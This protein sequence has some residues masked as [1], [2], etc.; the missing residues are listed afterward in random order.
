MSNIVAIVGRPNVGKSTLFNRLIEQKKA[1]MDNVSGVTRDRHYGYGQW[2]GKFF[3][4][5]DTGGYVHGSEDMFEGAIRE[6]VEMAME[7]ADVLLFVV[8][9][10]VGL[11]DLDKD[12]AKVLRK[13]KKPVI[14]VANKADTHDKA[15]VAAEFY[16]LGLGDP[17]AIAAESGSGTGD[18]LD[19]MV[20]HFKEEGVE[21]PEAGVPRV[22]ILGRP[23]VGK[24]SFLNAL[25]GRERS[26][27]TD[28]AGT[29][30][31]A[32]QNRYTLYGKDF[33]ITDTAGIRRKAKIDD[34]IEYYSVLR[35]IKA[36]EECDLA[37]ILVDA[38]TIDFNTG[39]EAQDMNIISMADKAKK[40]IVLMVNKWDL[41]AK[42]TNTAIKLEN[43]IKERLAPINYMPVIFTSVMEKKRI[44]QV[45]EKML[46]VFEN[47]SQKIATSKLNDVMLEVI[48][49]YPPPAWKG[50]YIKIKYCTQVSTPYP[51]FIFFC[52]LPQYIKE[53]YERYLENQMR[54]A[55][56]LEGTPISLF[57]RKK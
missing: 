6:Q 2:T 10:Q 31:D 19:L 28:L 57:F 37:I 30:R 43:A 20:S 13:S 36:M 12:F 16:E 42:D 53:S 7:E 29:T 47:R 3:T 54:K 46:E 55:F 35:S 18:M 27:V 9:C 49:N 22:A 41:V 48:N 50:K 39:L 56:K 34:N 51:T 38:T 45:V 17:Y 14:I 4:V 21:N 5:I 25:L 23:N 8:D 44:F 15:F 40:G 24:S 1:I 11:T 32:I 52:N 26:I 33:I